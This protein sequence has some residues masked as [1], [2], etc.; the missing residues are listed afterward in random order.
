MTLDFGRHAILQA[1]DAAP[2]K[3]VVVRDPAGKPVPLKR[4]RHAKP[5]QFGTDLLRELANFEVLQPG[6]Y[7]VLVEGQADARPDRHAGRP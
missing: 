1:S 3:S 6:A 5:R 2:P 4:F 7:T